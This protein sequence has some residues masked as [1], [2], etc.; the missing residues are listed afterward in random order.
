[1]PS[2]VQEEVVTQTSSIRWPGY[3]HG[4]LRR[5]QFS[6]VLWES[7]V[8]PAASRQF[9]EF[10]SKQRPKGVWNPFE[11]IEQPCT[12][13]W[14]THRARVPHTTGRGPHRQRVAHANRP[15][16]ALRQP[17]GRGRRGL[18]VW[19]GSWA[20]FAYEHFHVNRTFK[21]KC[22]LSIDCINILSGVSE[23]GLWKAFPES[24]LK[25]ETRAL[26]GKK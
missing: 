6:R 3:R 8:D 24:S 16:S 26:S 15:L 21:G 19:R 5:F 2:S 14:H 22:S 4:M 13:T 1:M 25:D 9:P 17:S 7:G 18:S 12:S 11:G 10:G 23:E 20:H